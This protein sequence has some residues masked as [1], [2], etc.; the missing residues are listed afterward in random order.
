MTQEASHVRRLLQLSA[1]K[2]K[3]TLTGKQTIETRRK[4]K[5]FRNA[6]YVHQYFIHRQ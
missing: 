4:P 1:T 3:T 5:R 2:M 6:M